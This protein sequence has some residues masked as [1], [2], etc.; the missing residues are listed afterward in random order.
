MKTLLA[1]ITLTI[2]TLTIFAQGASNAYRFDGDGDAV[3]FGAVDFNFTDQMTVMGW[4]KWNIDP[5]NGD[6][7]ANIVTINSSQTGDYGQFWIQ[8]D[9]NNNKLEF[10]LQT[11]NNRQFIWSNTHVQEGKWVHF[12]AS[13]DGSVQRLYINGVEEGHQNRSGDIN[14][15]QSDF[16]LT[17]A[18]WAAYGGDRYF[19]GDL[20]EVSIWNRALT[21]DEIRNAMTKKLAGDENDL[22]AYYRFDELNAGL[23]SD[24]V[25]TYDGNV[26]ET[27]LVTSTAPVGDNNAWTYEGDEL[28]YEGTD[29]RITLSD[30]S[31]N[32]E[33]IHIYHV[34]ESPN[35]LEVANPDI[36]EIVDGGYWGIFVVRN[37]NNAT[38][39]YTKE[40][41]SNT[42][43][44]VNDSLTIAY[45]DNA[46][47]Q[48]NWQAIEQNVPDSSG[49]FYTEGGFYHREYILAKA[50]PSLLPIELSMFNLS[51][52]DNAVLIEWETASELNNDY[53]LIERS[54]DGENWTDIATVDGAGTSKT[55]S[56]YEYEDMN[57]LNGTSYYRL[58]QVDYDGASETFSSKSIS[59]LQNDTY[60]VETYPN[61]V[62]DRLTVNANHEIRNISL[63]TASGFPVH[64]ALTRHDRSVVVDMSGLPAGA[65]VLNIFTADGNSISRKVLKQN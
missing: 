18:N 16:N 31:G 2:F 6:N 43:I 58:R 13:Y 42:S 62:K 50:N 35:T 37:G 45:R 12:A 19:N 65:Y 52:T 54:G 3:N 4:M 36:S 64:V 47:D 63:Y 25:G 21:P 5:K 14:T 28:V 56:Y 24:E 60:K 8:H 44:N 39:K 41:L 23:L 40:L 51:D 22:L 9:R 7:W 57:P 38:F 48:W 10:A 1:T 33:G 53:F 27:Q 34:S 46:S 15:F 11:E 49:F 61:P 30:F 32:M 20:D 17:F 29:H 26:A 59:F 55:A